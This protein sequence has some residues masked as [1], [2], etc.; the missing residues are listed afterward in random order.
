MNRL[1]TE[2]RAQIV[3]SL[4]EGTSI[5]ATVRMTGAAKNT[6]TKLLTDLGEACADYQD[7]TLLDLPCTTVQCDEIWAYCYA[8]QK[9]VPDEHRGTFGYGDV[10]TWTALCADTKLVPAWLVGERTYDDALT[11][12]LDLQKRLSRPVQL[13]TDGNRTYLEAVDIAFWREKIDYAML[14]KIYGPDPADER[15]YSPPVCNGTT[16]HVV[17]GN[18][19]PEKIST[20]YVERQNLT[21]RMGMRRFTRLTN[22]FSKKVENLAHAVSLHYLHYNFARPHKTLSKPY[23]TTPA[24]A[25]GL[26]DHVWTLREIAELLD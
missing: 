21:M 4:V 20:S 13:T 12:M 18:P 10:W 8:K 3:G 2:K 25:A 26:A 17:K 14:Q 1:T 23:P 16:T 19:D 11:F 15:R 9:N 5:R 24:M 6:V 22:G 7:R